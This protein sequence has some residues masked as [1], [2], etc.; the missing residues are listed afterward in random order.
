M[1]DDRDIHFQRKKI[2]SASDWSSLLGLFTFISV[3][4]MIV[5]FISNEAYLALLL[6][7]GQI[8]VGIWL[9]KLSAAFEALTPP[10]PQPNAAKT[11]SPGTSE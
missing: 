10:A 6:V 1:S 7:P 4:M 11:D 3:L 8:M 9:F 2:R 5:F